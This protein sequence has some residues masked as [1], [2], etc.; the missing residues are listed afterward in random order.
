MRIIKYF[1]FFPILLAAAALNAQS[2][3]DLSAGQGGLTG[4]SEYQKHSDLE[5]FNRAAAET[6]LP[7]LTPL[8]TAESANMMTV[9]RL[10][11]LKLNENIIKNSVMNYAA[12]PDITAAAAI[13]A[14]GGAAAAI[15]KFE[16]IIVSAETDEASAQAAGNI[17]VISLFAGNYKKAREY[18]DQ[19]VKLDPNNPF[20]QFVK[21]L[22]YAA[23]GDVKKAK[24]EYDKLLFL[25]ADFEYAS[26]AKLAIAQADF[27]A[28]RYKDAIPT[29]QNLYATDPYLISHSIYLLGVIAYKQGRYNIAQTLFE[30]ALAHD[31]NNYMAQKYNAMTLEK[32]KLNVNA[33]QTYA[34]LFM[35][36]T[37]NTELAKKLDILS[38]FLKAPQADYLFYT[39]INEIFNKQ[40]HESR[41]AHVRVGLYAQYSGALTRVES[42]TFLPG[43]AFSIK[44]EKLGKVITGEGFIAKTVIFDK[45][46][47]SAHIQNKWNTADFSTKRPFVIDLDKEGYTILIK[48]IKTQD[49]FAT[50]TGDKELRGSIMVIPGEGGMVLINYTALEDILPSGIMSVARGVKEEAALE[51][52][53]IVLRTR[54]V[55]ELKHTAEDVYDIPDNTPVFNYG[56]VNM[57]TAPA[58][59][60]VKDTEGITL[61]GRPDLYRSCGAVADEGVRNTEG[62][63]NYVYTPDNLLKFMISNPPKDLVSAPQDSTLWAAVKWVYAFPVKDIEARLKQNYAAIGALQ[64][65]E[66]AELSPSGRILKMRFNG[67]K[68][69]VEVPFKEANFILSSGTLRSNFFYALPFSNGGKLVEYLFIGTDTGLGKGMCIDGAAGMAREGKT[70]EEIL[71]Y[72]YPGLKTSGTWPEQKSLL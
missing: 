4:T 44:D 63:I 48:D 72:Y 25:T 66:P 41:G 52:A 71:R 27:I 32:Q 36:D 28:G 59:N 21:I 47:Q 61:K 58:K 60:A 24:K 18:I 31:N 33:W 13:Y 40:Q 8:A 20:Y 57:Q 30:Q 37:K 42:F 14:G 12:A 9:A 46:N 3:A 5:K 6:S 38:K 64:S 43:A 29:L 23:Q 26:A 35:L 7:P 2:L 10:P 19:A 1:I 69:S 53:A 68:G 11:D 15:Q 22:I 16:D 39:R 17:S 55:D 50:N 51:A 45:E 49:I 70:A 56:G 54:L 62:K 67:K 34:S 65:I